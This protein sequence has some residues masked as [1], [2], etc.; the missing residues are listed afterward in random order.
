MGKHFISKQAKCPYYKH[1]SHPTV[2]CDG[3]MEGSTIHISFDNC[4]KSKAYKAEFCYKAYDGCPIK[5][6]LDAEWERNH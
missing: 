2:Y 6:M 5:R 4:V 1:E 3:A